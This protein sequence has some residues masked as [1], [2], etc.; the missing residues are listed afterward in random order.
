MKRFLRKCLVFGA[1][2]IGV[3]FTSCASSA[4]SSAQDTVSAQVQDLVYINIINRRWE[5]IKITAVFDSKQESLGTVNAMADHVYHVDI[6]DVAV[7]MQLILE[8]E[9]RYRCITFPISAV[10]GDVLTLRMSDQNI[11]PAFC[12]PLVPGTMDRLA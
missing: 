9:N 5:R 10:P 1:L 8:F 12:A 7:G 11:D 2:V 6:G 3:G 4:P